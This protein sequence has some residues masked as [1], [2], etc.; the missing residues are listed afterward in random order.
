LRPLGSIDA[1]SSRVEPEYT[2]DFT[3]ASLIVDLSPKSSVA[4]SRR[5]LPIL[6]EK[7]GAER[8]DLDELLGAG[9][10]V[11]PMQASVT[12]ETRAA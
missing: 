11:F 6:R 8:A 3:E 4:L 9:P 10:F 5:M 7:A 2:E 12:W 1:R